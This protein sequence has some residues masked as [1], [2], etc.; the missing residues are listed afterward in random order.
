MTKKR[1][2]FTLVEIMVVV[3]IILILA[4]IAIPNMV[5]SKIVGNEASAISVL[6]STVT[7]CNLYTLNENDY[8]D[9]IN[10]LAESIP[11][12]LNSEIANAFSTATSQV[13]KDGYKFT[14]VKSLSETVPGFYIIARPV[15]FGVSGLRSFYTTEKSVITYCET[16]NCDPQAGN[17]I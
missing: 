1:S 16:S 12:Y 14:Y 11:P 17:E 3:G 4:V 8:P 2:G 5:R 15:K 7:S 6:K 10:I 13:P 9:T